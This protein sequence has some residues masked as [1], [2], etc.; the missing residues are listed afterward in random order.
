MG[1]SYLTKITMANIGLTSGVLDKAVSDSP[2]TVARVY[3]F[4]NGMETVK[5]TLGDSVR[6]SGEVEAAN[7]LNGELFRSGKLFV[8]AVGEVALVNE[9]G[10]MEEGEKLKFGMEIAIERNTGKG[11]GVKYK[12]SIKPLIEMK[13]DDELSKMRMA[14]PAPGAKPSKKK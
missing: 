10:S 6:F 12:Y 9:L 5:T 11:G 8:P 4:L 13:Q 14:L 1:A 7:L 3:G 2:V